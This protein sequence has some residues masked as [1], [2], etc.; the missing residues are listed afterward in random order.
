MEGFD[1][2]YGPTTNFGV[3]NGDF[4]KWLFIDDGAGNVVNHDGVGYRYDII[5]V[6]NIMRNEHCL[7]Y[8]IHDTEYIVRSEDL[9]Y[10]DQISENI[11]VYLHDI[12]IK[13]LEKVIKN[14]NISK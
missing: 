14:S 9:R 10:P 8:S 11:K 6:N 13:Y 1:K 3:A 5:C 4:M 7:P 12:K 2:I